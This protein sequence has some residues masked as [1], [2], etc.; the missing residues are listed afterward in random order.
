MF[1]SYFCTRIVTKNAILFVFPLHLMRMRLGGPLTSLSPSVA[2]EQVRLVRLVAIL[3]TQSHSQ[4]CPPMCC[5]C[6]HHHGVAVYSL[7][8][9]S[10]H[11]SQGVL[12]AQFSDL[13]SIGSAAVSVRKGQP[14][15]ELSSSEQPCSSN[16]KL[17][18]QS[19]AWSLPPAEKTGCKLSSRCTRRSAE[20]L[21]PKTLSC[22]TGTQL[23]F[24]NSEIWDSDTADDTLEA[25]GNSMHC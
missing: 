3:P 17:V 25:L 22:D 11:T 24:D 12:A 19:A 7:C 15:L 10:L 4:L 16:A 20:P 18:E 23:R 1:F 9:H 13:L 21:R 8:I 6:R 5:F 14:S 2:R